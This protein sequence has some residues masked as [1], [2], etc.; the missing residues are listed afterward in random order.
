MKVKNI[1]VLFLLLPVIQ[2]R[3]NDYMLCQNYQIADIKWMNKVHEKTWATPHGI[4]NKDV[5]PNWRVH[6][7][8]EAAR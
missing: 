1:V 4:N 6:L 5:R 3:E 8:L 2:L 7:P